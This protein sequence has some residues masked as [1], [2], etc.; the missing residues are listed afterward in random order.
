MYMY[1]W[2]HICIHIHKA[3]GSSTIHASIHQCTSRKATQPPLHAAFRY[4]GNVRL[5]C[6]GAE[7]AEKV[8]VWICP[9]VAGA[10]QGGREA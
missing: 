6:I 9:E 7:P 1:T 8:L 3:L 10:K 2:A 4:V 5:A